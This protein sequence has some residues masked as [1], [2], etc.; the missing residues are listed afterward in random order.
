MKHITEG[1]LTA[2]SHEFSVYT[3]NLS[4]AL[5][6]PDGLLEKSDRGKWNFQNAFDR[7]ERHYV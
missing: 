2:P 5:E 3:L 1:V 4:A 6:T 7:Q